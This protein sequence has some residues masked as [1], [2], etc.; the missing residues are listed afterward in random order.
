MDVYKKLIRNL[1]WFYFRLLD[2]NFNNTIYEIKI[3]TIIILLKSNEIK[4]DINDII[5]NFDYDVNINIFNEI[6][7]NKITNKINLYYIRLK[8]LKKILL[9]DEEKT[10]INILNIILDYL[11]NISDTKYRNFFKEH[12][13]NYF[14]D[15]DDFI[16]KI[17]DYN[18]NSNFDDIYKFIIFN[19]IFTK[20]DIKYKK[21]IPK[22]LRIK[23]WN[24]YIGEEI[25]KI[26][27][28][29]CKTIDITQSIFECGHI[30][31]EA[32]GGKT[33]LENLRPICS[34]CN[35]SMNTINMYDFMKIIE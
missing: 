28:L 13:K 1:N 17:Y 18:Y 26:K 27:C 10:K 9:K 4:I 15:I 34:T 22:S 12:L 11:G 33:T 30:I 21:T 14:E 20:R 31:A 25:G 5:N 3:K 16:N 6:K 23:V 7:K 29:C 8:D 35:K 24:T 2:T 19:P 32:K